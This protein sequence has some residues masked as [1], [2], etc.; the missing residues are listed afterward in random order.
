[1]T[2]TSVAIVGAAESAE[3]GTVEL[4]ALGLEIGRAHV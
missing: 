3:I 1:M 4:S 2:A